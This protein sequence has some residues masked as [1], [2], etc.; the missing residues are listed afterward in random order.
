M[1]RRCV[2][3]GA[4]LPEKSRSDR[5]TCSARCR[6]TLSRRLR[7]Q[8]GGRNRREGAEDEGGGDDAG[9]DG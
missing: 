9:G 3:C 2:I 1:T 8:P 4:S 6:V 7:Q 5:R